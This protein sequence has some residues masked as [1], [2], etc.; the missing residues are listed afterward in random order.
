MRQKTFDVVIVGGGVA[1]LAAAEQLSQAKKRVLLLEARNYLG[2]RIRT[3]SGEGPVPIELGAEFLH[4]LS[5]DVVNTLARGG[6]RPL[7]GEGKH[8][9]VRGKGL[10]EADDFWPEIERGLSQL[11][12][13]RH[14]LPISELLGERNRNRRTELI[15]QFVE[16]FNA[17]PADEISTQATIA[18]HREAMAADGYQSF[19]P[20]GGYH[21][22]IRGH[23]AG[24]DP[25]FLSID[26][27]AVV[28]NITWAPANVEVTY[29]RKTVRRKARAKTL[30]ITVPPSVLVGTG[31]GSISFSPAIP[32]K[33]ALAR[34]VGVGAV[35]K[36]VLRLKD[37][38]KPLIES[39]RQALKDAQF[40]HLTNT[41]FQTWWTAYPYRESQLVAWAGGPNATKLG[42][43]S[44]KEL[45]QVVMKTLAR[46]LRTTP[47]AASRAV[48]G[49][50]IH[51]WQHDPFAR[52]AYSFPRAGAKEVP[53]QLSRPLKQTLFFAGE[54][55]SSDGIGGTV[56]SA[57]ESGKRA[58][59]QILRAL[60]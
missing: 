40:F 9:S 39:K 22:L 42:Q 51:D 41:P 5:E 6:S 20:H 11:R 3:V 54:A 14:D 43:L 28:R 2:G 30:L 15:Y 21:S 7:L 32:E 8:W 34:K 44:R 55:T 36:V 26:L 12:S 16:G 17:A 4:E 47:S 13:P 58:A 33:L 25:R 50:W 10:V 53:K 23:L 46:I 45:K 57:L 27:Q 37:N 52:G 1:G 60:D 59:K 35:V 31:A 56:G 49:M 48:M 29:L 19:R 18:A 38:D 24:I